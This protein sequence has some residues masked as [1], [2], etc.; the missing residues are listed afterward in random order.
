MGELHIGNN[1]ILAS[2][3][4]ISDHN[5][6]VY[7]DLSK[8]HFLYSS[9]FDHITFSKCYCSHSSPEVPP[10]EHNLVVKPICIKNN[11]WIGESVSILPGVNIGEGAVI[12]AG[13]VVTKDVDSNTL[14]AGNPAK[15]IKFYN[16]TL[17]KWTSVF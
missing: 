8:H 14:V 13:S 15:V 3:I 5:H 7:S 9:R 17:G 6:G 12:G 10:S 4:F 2:K 16:N 1:C 11:V